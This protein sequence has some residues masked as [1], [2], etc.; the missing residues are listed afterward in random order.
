MTTEQTLKGLSASGG[1]SGVNA[2]NVPQICR[3][4]GHYKF[5][6]KRLVYKGLGGY[7]YVYFTVYSHHR[8]YSRARADQLCEKVF[9]GGYQPIGTPE[10]NDLILVRPV[11]E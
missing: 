11:G 3:H 6:A 9:F 2:L 4:R 1:A 7:D 10:E 5:I 8:K